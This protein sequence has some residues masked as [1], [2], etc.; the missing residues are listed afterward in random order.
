MKIY[1]IEFFFG[2]EYRVYMVEAYLARMRGDFPAFADWRC[3]AYEAQRKLQVQR[4]NRI[5]GAL[6]P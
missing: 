3:K 4:L 1:L 6:R 2:F 5:Y